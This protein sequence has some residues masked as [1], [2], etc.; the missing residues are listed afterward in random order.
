MPF[1]D[2]A[3]DSFYTQIYSEDYVITP[4][5]PA[6]GGGGASLPFQV[7]IVPNSENPETGAPSALIGEG[8][9]FGAPYLPTL[10]T[11]TNK[12]AVTEGS[13][14]ITGE[15]IVYIKRDHPSDILTFVIADHTDGDAFTPHEP[16]DWITSTASPNPQLT[17]FFHPIATIVNNPDAPL[18]P[19]PAQQYVVR[20]IVTSH[21]VL[22][23]ICFS[24]RSAKTFMPI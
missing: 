24:G 9:L 21:L 4:Q 8:N 2:Y 18:D 20:Q 23:N 7:S 22:T 11:P 5:E 14:S 15:S 3:G 17:A 10:L 13:L 19:T 16:E 1:P 12:V 6:S